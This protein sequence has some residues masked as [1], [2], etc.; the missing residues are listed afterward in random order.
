MSNLEH[1]PTPPD[2]SRPETSRVGKPARTRLAR[3]AIIAAIVIVVIAGI[4]I[5]Y[6][7]TPDVDKQ[8]TS[9]TTLPGTGSGA[10]TINNNQPGNQTQTAPGDRSDNLHRGINST[11]TRPS[12]D[13]TQR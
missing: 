13:G 2:D 9:S 4:S 6:W 12:N 10:G 11:P 5:A 7:S 8:T 3:G 1:G